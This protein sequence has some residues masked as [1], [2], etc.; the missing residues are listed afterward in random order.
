LITTGTRLIFL[1]RLKVEFF[2]FNLTKRSNEKDA[3]YG[4]P[5]YWD[6][7]RTI[8]TRPEGA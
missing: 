2:K 4:G 7:Q 3:L 5:D 1:N 8:T 6:P